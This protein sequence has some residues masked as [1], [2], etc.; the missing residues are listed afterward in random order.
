MEIPDLIACLE[1]IVP[2]ANKDKKTEAGYV[3]FS[4]KCRALDE[5]IRI[6]E[7]LTEEKIAN[8][9]SGLSYGTKCRR[10]GDGFDF[11]AVREQLDDKAPKCIAKAIIQSLKEG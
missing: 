7:N 2:D 4:V 5:A 10:F 11:V 9:L 1:T 3:V 8:V 6:L